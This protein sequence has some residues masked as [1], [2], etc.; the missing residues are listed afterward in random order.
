MYKTNYADI[1]YRYAI[2]MT[3]NFSLTCVSFHLLDFSYYIN[4]DGL[5]ITEERETLSETPPGD[6]CFDGVVLEGES[7]GESGK[8]RTKSR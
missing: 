8:D 1:C 4:A 5:L 3:H 7:P 2:C 6:Y